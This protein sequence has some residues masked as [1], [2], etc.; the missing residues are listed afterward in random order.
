MNTRFTTTLFSLGL[1]MLVVTCSKMD[2]DTLATIDGNAISLEEFTSKN[3]A[4][5][6]ADKDHDFMDSK[7]D[8]HVRKVLFSRAALDQ[9]MGE[10]DDI[11]N[12]KMK[13]EKRQMLQYVYT[14]EILDAVVSD[15]YVREVYERSGTELN[16]RHI[17]LQFQGT[18]RSRSERTKV[19]ALALMGQINNRLSKGETFEEL[20]S[21]FTDDPSGKQNG[22]DLG[23]FGWGKMVGPFQET[24]FNLEPGEVSNVVETD[25]GFHIIK[26][27]AKRELER[28]DFE[29]EKNALK[30]QAS[31]EKSAE[32]GQMANQFLEG[33]KKAAGFEIIT[34]NVHDFFMIFDGSSVKKDAI[35][36]MLKKLDFQAPLFRLNGEE[37]GS[38][39]L[40][41]EVKLLDDGQKPRFVTENQL[42]G[43]IDQIVTQYLII[44][45]GYDNKF[46]QDVDFAGKINDLV[47]RYA[48]DA[49]VAK[50]INSDLTPSEEELVAFYDANKADK[51]MDKKKVLVREVFVK[52][53]LFAVSLKKRLD[54][55]E[56][57]EK[58][59]LRYTERKAT[60]EGGGVLPAFQEG[61]YGSMGKAA[62][63]M[64]VGDIAGPIKLG[65]GYS[66]IQLEDIIPEGPKPYSKV[67]G[68]VRT[69]ILSD[70]RAAR[71]E[72]AYSDLKKDYTVKVNYS[73]AHA[74]YE[75][76]AGEK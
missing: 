25:F 64:E 15:D 41:G 7:V 38:D 61:R 71:T 76:L 44:N 74:F 66:I 73:A 54:A 49:F 20:A 70:L 30:Q 1:L 17:L 45:Y 43:I 55:G 36:E 65:N 47:E 26:L 27:E 50:E 4:S 28:G 24:A 8:E 6:F 53:S 23:W 19:E 2:S 31:R 32:L 34:E 72:N 62:F 67:K 35:D 22:G 58:L 75:N 51:Y 10:T 46:E 39:W 14:K 56:V 69:E 12:K 33:Q 40:V 5:R 52:D 37:L 57:I 63:S 29:T 68:R 48:Y 13:A 18:S 3:P 59:A 21:E 11:K 9:G 16:A 60:K 42:L